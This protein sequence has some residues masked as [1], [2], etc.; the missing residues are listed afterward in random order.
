MANHCEHFEQLEKVADPTSDV[1]DR[2]VEMGDT[3]VHLRSCLICGTVG[4]CDSS[5]NR[6]AR[7]HWEEHGH[8]LVQS[9]EPLEFWRYCFADQVLVK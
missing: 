9:L 4:C 1:C 8:P 2:C 3:W 5:K 6:H 7:K